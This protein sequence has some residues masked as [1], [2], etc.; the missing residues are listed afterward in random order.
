MNAGLGHDSRSDKPVVPVG[1]WLEASCLLEDVPSLKD[2]QPLV[3]ILILPKNQSANMLFEL[4][5][6]LKTYDLD[7]WWR[8][9]H[10]LWVHRTV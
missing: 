8:I 10:E 9:S 7:T 4:R 3:Q 2:T 6:R 5:K 1:A